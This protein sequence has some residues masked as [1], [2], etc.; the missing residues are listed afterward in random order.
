MGV[1]TACLDL[2]LGFGSPAL[3]WVAGR[4]NLDTVFAVSA[5]V[6]LVAAIISLRLQRSAP[7][8][9]P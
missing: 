6:V 9:E 3:G 5:A 8:F 2:A 1:Y 4:T 7:A